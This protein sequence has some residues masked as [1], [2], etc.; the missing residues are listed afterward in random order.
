MTLFSEAVQAS[1][2]VIRD[3]DGDELFGG[4]K[5]YVV[6]VP[7]KTKTEF[8]IINNGWRFGND[9]KL[10]AMFFSDFRFEM[11]YVGAEYSS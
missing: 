9:Y 4:E 7:S 10:L 2:D 3:I 8:R 1:G 6:V 5:Y 11:G